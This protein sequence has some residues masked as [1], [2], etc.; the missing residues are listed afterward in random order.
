MFK[1][2]ILVLLTTFST[3]A[4]AQKTFNLKYGVG[5]M[6]SVNSQVVSIAIQKQLKDSYAHQLE[7]GAWFDPQEEKNRRSSGFCSYSLGLRVILP[8]FYMESMHGIGG[9]SHPDSLLGG[10]VKLFNNFGLGIKDRSGNALGVV[11]KHVSSAGIE[12]PN[13]G[14]NFA[15]AKLSFGF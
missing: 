12:K 8:N 1:N 13:M 15:A 9:I 4:F 2:L 7:C 5:V 14:R 6:Q 11:F 3:V 10:R